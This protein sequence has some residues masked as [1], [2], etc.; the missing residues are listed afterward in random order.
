[1]FFPT[2]NIKN[3]AFVDVI[4][5]KRKRERKRKRKRERT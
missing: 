5:D 2:L 4:D 3:I 1:M